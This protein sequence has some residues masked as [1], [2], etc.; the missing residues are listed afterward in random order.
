M[1]N[2]TLDELRVLARAYLDATGMSLTRLS[3]TITG[4]PNNDKLIIGI[5]AGHSCLT[6]H[7]EAASRYFRA[8]WPVATP[9]PLDCDPPYTTRSMRRSAAE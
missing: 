5:L 7:S 2:H 1:V 4:K 8:N 3:K 6:H 9:W